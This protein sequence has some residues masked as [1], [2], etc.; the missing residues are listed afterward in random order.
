MF[1]IARSLHAAGKLEKIV[2]GYPQNRLAKEGLPKSKNSSYPLYQVPLFALVRSQL[3][4]SRVAKYVDKRNLNYLDHKTKVIIGNSNLIAMSSLGLETAHLVK[5]RGNVFVVNRWS[6]HII[7]QQQILEEQAANWGW[8]EP[9]PSKASI[10]REL[11]EYQL[12]DKII[13]PSRASYLSF[14]HKDID[15]SKVV[16]NPFPLPG[17][18]VLESNTHKKDFLFVGNVTLQKG[19][20]TLIK[21]FNSLNL[22]G[23]KLHVAGIY[24]QSFIDFL[25]KQ[26]LSFQNIVMHGHL[27]SGQL[28]KLYARCD[29]F[30]LPSVHDGWGM[31]VNEAMALGCIPIVSSSA[32]ASDQ[33]TNGLNGFTFEAG[34]AVGLAECMVAS[35]GN[36]DLRA[37]M[38][39]SFQSSAFYKRDWDDFCR[40]YLD[41]L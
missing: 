35:L 12:A 40:V 7:A 33:I 21:A 32:G 10:E 16:V 9:M 26:E 34:D 24:L 5:L 18:Q 25:R 4:N 15:M 20:P 38:I 37:R 36:E 22:K 28:S 17:L 13:V 3:G 27:S 14:Q 31:V 39:A 30:I 1:H 41:E 6:H 8:Q 2:S 11:E 19:F 23:V 29:V